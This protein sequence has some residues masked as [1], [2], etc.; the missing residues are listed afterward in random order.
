MDKLVAL[1]SYRRPMCDEPTTDEQLPADDKAW[2]MDDNP[3]V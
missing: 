2:D 1:E 3:G